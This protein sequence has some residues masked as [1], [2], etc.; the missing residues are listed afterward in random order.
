MLFITGDCHGD[1]RKF[2]KECFP[3]Q[4]GMTR[5][6]F[7][8][9]CGDFGIWNNG[10]QEQWWM[11]W[12]SQKPF[13][14][15]FVDGN[16]ENF[17][18]LNQFPVVDFHGGKAH[19]IKEN[20]YHL[21]RGELFDLCGKKVF[22]FGGASS[23]DIDDGILDPAKHKNWK[24]E[25]KK[26]R[27]KDKSFRVKGFSWW[28]QELPSKE[29]MWHGLHTLKQCGRK[30]DYIVSHCCPQ[31]I[32]SIFSSGLFKPDVLTAYFDEIL[33]TTKFKHWFFGH[34][35][36]NRTICG[37]FHMLYDQIVEMIGKE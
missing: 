31:T 27:R 17:D 20:I 2:N 5:E 37:K 16:H 10:K 25:A 6:D 23:H 35:H 13:T 19:Q 32:A 14:V 11:K 30:V 15:L 9:V 28:E 7:V 26:W 12:L 3:E 4:K 34:Y 1:Y 21:M 18:R 29:E 36:D 22:A 24:Q 33:E 8:L